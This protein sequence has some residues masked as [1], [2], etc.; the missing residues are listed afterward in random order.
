MLLS[1]IRNKVCKNDIKFHI[2]NYKYF[3]L[4]LDMPDMV[5]ETCIFCMWKLILS[6]YKNV[7][8][9]TTKFYKAITFQLKIN[10]LK[11]S[12]DVTYKREKLT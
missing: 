6:Q 5:R 12:F 4:N 9:K 1:L 10:K 7:W 8:Q 3:F 11:K 2:C